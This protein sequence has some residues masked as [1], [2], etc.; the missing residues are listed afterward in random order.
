MT[1][2]RLRTVACRTSMSGD[3]RK[4]LLD[5]LPLVLVP[6]N[7]PVERAAE[8]RPVKRTKRAVL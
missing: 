2:R 6:K 7:T 1:G 3:G 5:G 8:R 4:P